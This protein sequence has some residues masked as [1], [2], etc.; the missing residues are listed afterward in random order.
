MGDRTIPKLFL[1]LSVLLCTSKT[2]PQSDASQAAPVQT[3]LLALLQDYHSLRPAPEGV[4]ITQRTVRIGRL[5][6]ELEEGVLVPLQGPSKQI[7][8]AY[9][10]GRGIYFYQS[11][12]TAD[13]QTLALNLSHYSVAPR[14][15]QGTLSDPFTRALIVFGPP[16][17][18][19]ILPTSS[20]NPDHAVGV[21]AG[22]TSGFQRLWQAMGKAPVPWDHRATEA[23]LNGNGSKYLYAEIEGKSRPVGYCYDGVLSRDESLFF[24]ERGSRP[25]LRWLSALSIQPISKENQGHGPAIILK[26]AQIR[27]STDDNRSAR[28]TSDLTLQSARDG[29][30]A[31]R[32][33]LLNNRADDWADWAATRN[34]LFVRTVKDE[35]GRE[36]PYSHRY[37]EVLVEARQ[38]ASAGD[39]MNLRFDTDGA[40]LTGLFGESYQNYFDLFLVPWFP[41][42]EGWSTS[43]YT[44]DLKIKTRSPY[45]PVASGSTR[46]SRV[47][48]DFQELETDSPRPM[49]DIAVFGGKYT[50]QE[51]AFDR[52]T[53][54]VYAMTARKDVM[55]RMPSIA[56]K[57]LHFYEGVLGAYPFEDLDI[58]EIPEFVAE[59][60]PHGAFGI[61]PS[62]M[63][64]LTSE[65][66]TARRNYVTQYF[67]VGINARLAH[68]VAHQW[69][70]HK[71]MPASSRDWWIAESGAEYMAGM[72]MAATEPNESLVTGFPRMFAQWQSD[73]KLCED[74]PIEM[75][76]YLTGDSGAMKRFCLLY[77]RGPLVLHMLHTM[78]GNER[79]Y[80]ILKTFLDQANNGP[81]SLEDFQKASR[82]V[83]Q[84]DMDWFFQ[85]WFREAGT[86]EVRTEHTVHESGGKFT[87]I[88]RATQP[89]GT[90]FK[91]LLIPFVVD[92]G[93]GKREVK[94]LFEDK[95]EVEGRFDL[96]QKPQSV[97]V[98][99]SRNNL[100]VYR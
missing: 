33:A 93:A 53:V 57:F 96:L 29:V 79:F 69:F 9:F 65:A 36:L 25:E 67:S 85:Q 5:R 46:A 55:Q 71:A 18:P 80:A 68:E 35:T 72:A 66:Y 48:G 58:V 22:L 3:G 12:S 1:V 76:N 21:G 91:K 27:V 20:S 15:Q 86:P 7:L 74:T 43:G 37:H 16:M 94:L 100:A 84:S 44:F 59:Q 63:V 8:G 6:L 77:D 28:I 75:A 88:A 83:L 42:P 47:V 49:T 51:E 4:G 73:A 11:E 2:L 23:S 50:V 40:V 41:N 98:D 54:R 95:P 31:M 45:L 10:E 52:V 89:P 26:D 14:L 56:Y 17:L 19:E 38:A 39:F 82:E 24:F 81:A 97:A 32:L 64:L 13:R 99:P 34:Q 87:L 30:R 60:A 70:G 78:V 61:A 92:Y 90:S 62:G